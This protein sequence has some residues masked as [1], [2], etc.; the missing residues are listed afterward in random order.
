MREKRRELCERAKA[1]DRHDFRAKNGLFA[2]DNHY[3]SRDAA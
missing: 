3:K 2:L 1:P